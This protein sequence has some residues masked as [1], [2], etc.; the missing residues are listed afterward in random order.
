MNAV[1]FLGFLAYAQVQPADRLDLTSLLEGQTT[2]VRRWSAVPA[3]VREVLVSRWTAEPAAPPASRQEAIADPGEVFQEGDAV[4]TP[5]LPIRRLVLAAKAPGAWIV[6]YE[7]G[8][9]D[10]SF[11]LVLVPFEAGKVRG[12]PQWFW[13]RPPYPEDLQSLRAAIR[14]HRQ[15]R[16]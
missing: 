11:H 1:L 8:G 7:Q 2:E 12:Q 14:A 5:G 3:K 9:I 6:G 16:E 10:L 15:W 13:F 4:V